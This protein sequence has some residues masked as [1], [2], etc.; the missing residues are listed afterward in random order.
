MKKYISILFVFTSLFAYGQ[1]KSDIYRDIEKQKLEVFLDSIKSTI[2]SDTV[3]FSRS[4]LI[5]SAG[6]TQNKNLNSPLFIVNGKFSYKTDIVEGNEVV[7]FVEEILNVSKIKSITFVQ[8][9]YSQALYGSLGT[10]GTILI[11]LKKKANFNPEVAGLTL[12]AK[13]N[14]DQRKPG[15]L[16]IRH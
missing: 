7:R 16:T 12:T 14:F 2:L 8:P 15:E 5:H 13:N 9:K 3:K 4:H 1:K 11:T 10:G 6:I